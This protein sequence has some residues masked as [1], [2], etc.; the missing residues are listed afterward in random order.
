MHLVF[1]VAS[2]A[3]AVMVTVWGAAMYMSDRGTWGHLAFAAGSLA[4]AG[5]M[6][7]YLIGFTRKSRAIGMR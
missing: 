2:I 6:A 1:I 5:G 3:L 7:I 4:S